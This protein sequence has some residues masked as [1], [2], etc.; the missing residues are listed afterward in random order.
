MCSIEK[1]GRGIER[2][3]ENMKKA[4]LMPLMPMIS[5]PN[6]GVV[7]LQPL[8]Q[9]H[10]EQDPQHPH[11]GIS[12]R[13]VWRDKGGQRLCG[14]TQ[15]YMLM[16][17]ESDSTIDFRL[18]SKSERTADTIVDSSNFQNRINMNQWLNTSYVPCNS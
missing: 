17:A 2:C 7:E 3:A 8:L 15:V 5:T 18:Y 6:L 16:N 14:H 9:W 11:T 1:A 12:R 10:A 4:A 13:T